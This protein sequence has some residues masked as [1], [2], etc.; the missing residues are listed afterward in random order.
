MSRKKRNNLPSWLPQRKPDFIYPKEQMPA[1]RRGHV[2]E[3]WYD[4][5][6]RRVHVWLTERGKRSA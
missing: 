6:A 3:A 5:K 1:F 4:L 2:E